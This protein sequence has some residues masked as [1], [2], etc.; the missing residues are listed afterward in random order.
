[1]CNKLSDTL[2]CYKSYIYLNDF[3]QKEHE[4]EIKF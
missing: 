3:L 4:R 1:M 2:L